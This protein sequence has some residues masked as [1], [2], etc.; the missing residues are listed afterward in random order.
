MKRTRTPL[1]VAAI[2]VLV[3]G[4]LAPTA[5]S[6]RPNGRFG[7]VPLHGRTA[8]LDTLPSHRN[9]SQIVQ[10]GVQLHG[11]PVAV[12]EA[13]ALA[14]GNHLSES[15][16]QNVRAGLAPMQRR[17][18][19]QLRALGA[20]IQ[21]T[22]TDVFNGFRVAVKQSRVAAIRR[23]P[24]VTRVLAVPRET[25]SNLNTVPF[26]NADQAW[27][28]T[29]FTGKGV[30]IAIIDTGIN[31]YHED[32][33]GA[34]YAAWKADN[35]LTLGGTFPTA[36]VVDGYDLV[37]DDY[38][39]DPGSFPHPDPDPLDCKAVDA[40]NVQHGTH[41]A[42]TAA[43]YGVTASGHTYTGPWKGN[44]L[45]SNNFRIGPGVAPE[46]KL[47]AFRVFGCAGS[48][49]V[50]T[51]AIEMAVRKGADVISM[52]LG[53]TFGG[54][55]DLDS[56]AADNASLA[57]V[58]VVA[59]SGNEGPSAYVTGSPGAGERVIAVGA[60]DAERSFPGATINMASGPNI[61]AINANGGKLPV[62][63]TEHYFKDD[64]ST[65]G[66]SDTGA[67][68]EQS[69]CTPRSFAYNH[70]KKG[71]IAVVQRG[72]C[73]RTEK[74]AQGQQ[75]GA[76]A[77]VM[78]NNAN[79]FPPFEDTIP[80]VSIP[81]IGVS[82]T[83]DKRFSTDN[84]KTITINS[85]G[86][87]N[88]PN[89]RGTADFTSAGPGRVLD[90]IKPDVTAPGVG[91][92][93]ADGGTTTG[94]K[95]LSGTSMATPAVAGVAALVR[96]AHPGWLPN[97][98]KG[99]IVGTASAG[100]VKG[101]DVRLS[102]AGV[103][104]ARAAVD[105]KAF[106]TV[107]AATSSL[108]FGFRPSEKNVSGNNALRSSKTFRLVNT[109]TKA[110]T[111][112]FSNHL[113]T[114]RMGLHVSISPSSVTVPGGSGQAVTVT[115]TMTEAAAKA[116]PSAAPYHGP[117]L[118]QDRFGQLYTS[119]T[120]I[121]GAIVATPRSS[122]P[123]LYALRIPWMVLPQGTSSVDAL[124]G[125]RTPWTGSGN[126]IRSSID[127]RNRGL[128]D[129]IADVYSWGLTDGNERMGS[130]DM[131]AG[132]VQTTPASVCDSSADPSDRCLIFAINTWQRWSTASEDEFDVS[133]DLNGDGLEDY[134]VIGIDAGV[135][136]D[137]LY[138]IPLSVV[139][140]AATG[141][142]VSLYFAGASTN[143]STILLPVLASDIG[144]KAGKRTT[145]HYLASSYSIA[146][147]SGTALQADL[148]TTGSDPS[149]GSEWAT[150]NAF[151]PVTNNGTFRAVGPGD[152]QT[153]KLA[154]DRGRYQPR[155]HGDLG[156]M[157][158]SLDDRAGPSQADLVS[159]GPLP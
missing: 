91:V 15:A 93:S 52:S 77:V 139:V 73:A 153:V 32:F 124:T 80:R 150:Y 99:A 106:V 96:E 20:S 39:A 25:P 74:A 145:F 24:G 66:N 54:P 159:V 61:D 28:Q 143:G 123:G 23:L 16:K 40:E 83:E 50:V 152:D 42:G 94:G 7:P 95:S 45:N 60:V 58:V 84:G 127:V 135:V 27:G 33:G 140:D 14:S 136:F 151:R 134:F 78:V 4:A 98:V 72:F 100:L 2:V 76:S 138:G 56:V 8:N 147:G 158:V 68:F 125:S 11:S 121:A 62:T 69:G 3:I 156:W 31:Y 65:P 154:L 157:I 131:R 89:Y 30:K 37:G 19:T 137:A 22:Y 21:A 102:G 49:Y 51:D 35:G 34:G 132:G 59:A 149:Q 128:H 5:A 111:Y 43:G 85:A 90:L 122:G 10:V 119:I 130:S 18:S 148:M 1:F 144:L 79:G 55:G 48:T 41:V 146:D 115:V 63:A 109:G 9:G 70:F 64:P 129:G 133:I 92:F 118:A 88:N 17:V 113:N 141:G 116:L 29:G 38:T 126:V 13:A 71:E 36:K 114:A 57:G 103:V 104:N 101:Y 75:A 6:A 112:D 97:A 44:T 47:M 155:G 87:I 82:I 120:N 46:A 53:A 107:D 86:I 117:P 108:A 110:I 142:I 81:F 26:V 105:T 12:H 67:G